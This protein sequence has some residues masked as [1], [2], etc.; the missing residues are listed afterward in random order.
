MNSFLFARKAKPLQPPHAVFGITQRMGIC[1]PI[2]KVCRSSQA[3][4]RSYL[5]GAIDNET[6]VYVAANLIKIKLHHQ[7]LLQ[8]D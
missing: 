1:R 4:R 8:L 5:D 6:F 3:A 7:Y 2:Q